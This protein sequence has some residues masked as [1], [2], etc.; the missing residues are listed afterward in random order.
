MQSVLRSQQQKLDKLDP[1]HQ[2][3][4]YDETKAFIENLTGVLQRIH[5]IQSHQERTTKE[6]LLS[7]YKATLEGHKIE[8]AEQKHTLSL[9]RQLHRELAVT[10]ADKLEYQ[11]DD[12]KLELGSLT[13][14]TPAHTTMSKHIKNLEVKLA[15]SR[16]TEPKNTNNNAAEAEELPKLEAEARRLTLR[17]VYQDVL[18]DKKWLTDWD[19][20]HGLAGVLPTR[21]YIA[22]KRVH[23]ANPATLHELKFS[24]EDLSVPNPEPEEFENPEQRAATIAD[25]EQ[26]I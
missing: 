14:G 10:D 9:I 2:K 1:K 20:K 23:E 18:I 8:T 4:D 24:D 19:R 6:K 3:L 7:T 22:K 11:I 26:A 12:N 16:E 21:K 15:I 5:E 25:L 17:K 13:P